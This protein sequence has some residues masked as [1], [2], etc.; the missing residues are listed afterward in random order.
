M[1]LT[2]ANENY[3]YGPEEVK[4]LMLDGPDEIPCLISHATLSDLGV[5]IGL[6]DTAEIFSLYRGTIEHAASVKYDRSDRQEY[7]IVV[8]THDDL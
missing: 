8:V 1:P 3:V 5:R 2:R 4:F 6:S 7:E